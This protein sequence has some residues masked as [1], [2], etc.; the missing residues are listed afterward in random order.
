M[1]RILYEGIKDDNND[2][3]DRFEF[4]KLFLEKNQNNK[5]EISY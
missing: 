4:I 1:V 3:L 2:L 5:C